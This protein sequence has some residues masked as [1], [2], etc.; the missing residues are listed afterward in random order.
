MTSVDPVLLKRRVSPRLLTIRGVSGVGIPR[1]RLTVYLEKDSEA[2]RREVEAALA[3]AG[4]DVEVAFV[5][6]G[7]FRPRWSHPR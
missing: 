1:G 6:T 3:G 7:A 4:E 5:V 2:I